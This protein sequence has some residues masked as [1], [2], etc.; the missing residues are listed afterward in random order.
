MGGLLELTIDALGSHVGGIAPGGPVGRVFVPGALPG[1]RVSCRITRV[2]GDFAEAEL[3]EVLEASPERVSPFCPLFGRCGGCSLQHLA[4]GSQL[5]WK[6]DLVA[7]AL[8]RSGLRG[9]GRV[10]VIPS[11]RESGYRNR[12]TFDLVGGRP[13]LHRFRGDPLPVEGCPVLNSRGGEAFRT[14]AGTDLSGCGKVS[15]RASDATGDV[16]IELHDLSAP[17]APPRLPLSPGFSVAWDPGGGWRTSP[18]GA[19]LREE[20]LGC[21]FHIPPHAFFQGNTGAAEILVSIVLGACGDAAR[22]LDLYGGLGTFAVP[23]SL[24]GST[25]DSVEIEEDASIAGRRSAEATGAGTV[26]FV[27]APVRRFLESLPVGGPSWDAVVLDPPRGGLDPATARMLASLR[28]GRL[29]YVSCNPSALSRDLRVLLA[30][31]W[32]LREVQPV[33]MFPQT[34]HVETVVTLVPE[35]EA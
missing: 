5:R 18:P 32:A 29:I 12:V 25:V 34:D 10:E 20:L 28:T 19:F 14:I 26:R 17:S 2:R 30:G 21:T 9:R 11:P 7:G 1:E 15:V 3:V 8:E 35:G 23:L 31:G 6:S 27:T 22:V 24:R 13:G 33:D 16:L 4:Y